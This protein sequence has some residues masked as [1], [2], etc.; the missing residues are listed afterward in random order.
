MTNA[1]LL[2]QLFDSNGNLSVTT[3]NINTAGNL[4]VTNRLNVN[5]YSNLF[6]ATGTL[7]NT[8]ALTISGNVYGRGGIGYFDALTLTSNY[9]AATNPSKWIRLNPTGGLE[10]INSAYTTTIMSLSDGGNLNITGTYQVNGSQAVNGPAF[11]A[12]IGNPQT[13]TSGSQ[14]RVLFNSETFD[15]N[16]NFASNAF[17]PT[18][19][20]Y[21]Q[22]NATVR[23]AGTAGTGENMLILYKN[24]SEYARGTNG[25]GT[26]IGSNFYSM[27][28]SDVVYANGTTDYFEIY[29]QQGSGG[30]RDTTAGQNISYFSGVMVRGA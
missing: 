24:G 6:I 26:E 8:S 10:I 16:S 13:V 20:G 1:V 27:Q 21:Y 17:T 2:A 7:T 19:A 25:S 28:V 23:I 4:T 22:L 3:G 29:I 14:Q 15:T 5:S 12:Y 18:I 9:S 30:N 11:R